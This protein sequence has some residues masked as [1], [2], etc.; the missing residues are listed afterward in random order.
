[1]LS[2]SPPLEDEYDYF[3]DNRAREEELKRLNDELDI[4]QLDITDDTW[5]DPDIN[6]RTQPCSE[7]IATNAFS[8]SRDDH[9]KARGTVDK[10]QLF[11]NDNSGSSPESL[12]P[13]ASAS[14]RCIDVGATDEN[15]TQTDGIGKNATIRL[16]KARIETLDAQLKDSL[17][18]KHEAEDTASKLRLQLKDASQEKKRLQKALAQAKLLAGKS[19]TDEKST[20]NVVDDL[21]MELNQTKRE[22]TS[23]QRSLK[24]A[25]SEHKGREIRLSRALQEVEQYKKSVSSRVTE[26]RQDNEDVRRDKDKLSAQIKS[27]ERQRAELLT[28]FKKQ[29][30]LIDI[31]QK[32]K[33]HAEAAKLLQF[34]EEE[35]TKVIEWA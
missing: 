33:V 28:A 35:F 5:H 19:K 31:L 2:D 27:L 9:K 12:T 10:I 7:S 22:L 11:P 25:D 32:Q 4:Q 14:P 15:R 23:A 3:T 6:A 1:M 8:G 17:R 13:S 29:L 21:K 18:G 34:T 26:K 30:K 16:Q 24:V 20:R